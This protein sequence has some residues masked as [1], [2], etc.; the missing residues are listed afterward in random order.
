MKRAAPG[1]GSSGAALWRTL[2]HS[3]R[4]ALRCVALLAVVLVAMPAWAGT[5]EKYQCR[6]SKRVMSSCCCKAKQKA[7]QPAD[8]SPQAKAPSCCD[9]LRQVA[10]SAS[11]GLRDAAQLALDADLASSLVLIASPALPRS[12]TVVAAASFDAR[13]GPPIFLR[14]CRMLT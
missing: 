2:R 11:S 12:S 4:L 1:D 13:A 8:T 6:Y 5:A 7:V 14:D 10:S 3:R 9:T